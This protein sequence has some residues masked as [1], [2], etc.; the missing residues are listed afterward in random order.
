MYNFQH[1]N[2]IWKLYHKK[3]QYLLLKSARFVTNHKFQSLMFDMKLV[4]MGII[5]FNTRTQAIFL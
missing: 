1:I 5:S 4:C 3:V 2:L